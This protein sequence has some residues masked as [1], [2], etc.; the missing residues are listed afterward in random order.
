MTSF[1]DDLFSFILTGLIFGFIGFVI[2]CAVFT[3][4]K[5]YVYQEEVIKR[6]FAVMAMKDSLKDG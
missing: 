3:P 4:D 5:P 2:G 6:K 1:F